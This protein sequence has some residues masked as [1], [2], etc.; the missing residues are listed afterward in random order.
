M[1]FKQNSI[2]SLRVEI[3]T[4][5]DYHST[6]LSWFKDDPLI[7]VFVELDLVGSSGTSG[8]AKSIV[9]LPLVFYIY[10]DPMYH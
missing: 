9:F 10:S 7:C 5:I 1:I 8:N 3:Y 2:T 4:W 6:C